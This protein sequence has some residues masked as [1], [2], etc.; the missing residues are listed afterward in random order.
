MC[1]INVGIGPKPDQGAETGACFGGKASFG[2]LA[3]L[4]FPSGY[5]IY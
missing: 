3:T 5:G 4:I 1:C 2:A